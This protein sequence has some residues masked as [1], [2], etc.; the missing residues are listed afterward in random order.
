MP[1]T[2]TIA[3]RFCGPAGM[4]NGGYCCG[5]V[6]QAFDA[7][8]GRD[9]HNAVRVRLHAPVPL[10]TPLVLT[11]DGA[12][13]EL[14]NGE[15]LVASGAPAPL[16]IAPPPAPTR[17]AAA[18]AVQ[19]FIAYDDH[20]SPECFVCG[21]KREW[22]DA[23]CLFTGPLADAPDVVAA[24]WSPRAEFADENGSIRPEIVWAALD[25][26][27]YFA[28]GDASLRALL[29]TLTAEIY[30]APYAD[31]PCVVIGWAVSQDGRKHKGASALYGEGGRL[32]GAAAATWI[33]L[34][35]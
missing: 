30:E 23:L 31:E 21:P 24:P 16:E 35:Q 18:D 32:L 17:E 27:S 1:Q 2:I 25:C 9:A 12:A 7:V 3:P 28:F 14:R 26:P 15:T 8:Q 11:S 33:E 34:K 4:G 13:A 10:D 22:P 29:G 6:A 19:R 20:V 5:I